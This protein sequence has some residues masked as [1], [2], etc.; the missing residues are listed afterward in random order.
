MSWR[1]STVPRGLC[2]GPLWYV[3]GLGNA[4]GLRGAQWWVFDEWRVEQKLRNADAPRCGQHQLGSQL[5][6]WNG[7]EGSFFFFGWL[8]L[9]LPHGLWTLVSGSFKSPGQTLQPSNAEASAFLPGL[10]EDSLVNPRSSA[11]N[12]TLH[13][14]ACRRP[15]CILPPRFP[16]LLL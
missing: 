5:L 7:K 11:F 14:P 6:N 16:E 3:N 12:Y 4:S 9:I 13:S 2:D 15:F 10:S 1:L 8:F